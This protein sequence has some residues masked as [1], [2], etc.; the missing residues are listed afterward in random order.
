MGVVKN[1]QDEL[2]PVIQEMR[3][4]GLKDKMI[5]QIFEMVLEGIPLITPK[6]L[7]RVTI[8]VHADQDQVTV[9]GDPDYLIKSM[10][11]LMIAYRHRTSSTYGEALADLILELESLK[12][13]AIKERK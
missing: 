2:M 9:D 4:R 7:C 3:S 6:P 12:V 13:K 5:V 8:D 10:A 1:Y 11:S